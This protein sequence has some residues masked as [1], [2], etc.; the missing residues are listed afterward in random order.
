MA[1][2]ASV[3]IPIESVEA[4]AYTIPTD[5][6]ESDGTLAWDS[7]TFVLV[8][9]RAGGQVGTGYTY[10]GTPVVTVVRSKLADVVS[11]EDALQPPARWAQMQH[12]V[13]NLG[14]PGLAAEAISAVD[15]ALWD[16]RARLLDEPLVIAL[17]AIHDVTPIYGS[18]GF[19]SYDNDTLRAQLAGWVEAGIPRVKMKV[20]R[21]PDA[22]IGRVEA[23]R[24]AIGDDVELFVDANGAYHRKQA[25]WW[26]HRFADYDV[27][28]F[29]EPV[30]SDDL[31]GLHQLREHGPAGMDIAAGEYGY[32]LP[33][34]HQ[35]LAAG[36]VDCLQ[37]DVTR[38]LGITGVLKVAALCDARGMDLSLHCA[39][40]I[41][42]QVGTA[43]W[44]MRHLEYF[45][46]H[47][48][49]EGLAFDGTIEPEAGG[50]LR[51][52]RSAPGHGLTV[53]HADLEQFRVA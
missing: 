48:R 36:A 20:G 29:E 7:T 46:D 25:L 35:M 49:I 31:D 5:A 38:A 50:V 22:D 19:T 11:G 41:S 17:G 23:A 33:Y 24:S 52:D 1:L 37:A 26:A 6:P 45:H 18:G 14:K 27:W 9:A 28:W 40:Q 43:V 44:H 53:K 3:P 2:H 32:H 12:A 21:D 15:I 30:S 42:A 16:L 13:R 10:A 51:P 4:A 34:F 39:P 8:S 47:I